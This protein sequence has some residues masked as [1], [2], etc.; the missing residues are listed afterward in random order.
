MENKRRF[1]QLLY[2]A[3]HSIKKRYTQSAFGMVWAFIQ[4]IILTM[5]FAFFAENGLRFGGDVDGVPFVVIVLIGNITFSVVSSYFLSA[6]NILKGNVELLKMINIPLPLVILV[7]MLSNFFIHLCTLTIVLIYFQF[8]GYEI[9]FSYINFLFYWIV[10]FV[11][12]YG[13]SYIV[14]LVSLLVKDLQY[15]LSSLM[16]SLYFI[17]PV[18]WVPSGLAETLEKI[19]N[20]FYFFIYGYRM[21]IIKNEFFWQDSMYNAYIFLQAIL[22]LAIARYLH[23]KLHK[24]VYDLV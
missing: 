23:K 15:L 19:F 7:E 4:P 16:V 12:F 9:N 22:L 24:K 21:T 8:N 17:T 1:H 6:P 10:M 3:F 5:S 18:F 20:P 14:A 11:Y 13:Y 2:I